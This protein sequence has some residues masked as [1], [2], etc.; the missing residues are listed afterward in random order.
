MI[1]LEPTVDILLSL[2]NK[3][4]PDQV[5]AGFALETENGVTNARKKLKGKGLNLIVLN[6]P[7]DEGAAFDYDTNRVTIIT[8]RGKPECWPLLNKDQIAFKLLEKLY[9]ML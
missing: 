3:R 4:R 1:K 8:P 6:N 9:S 7:R 5:V 2:K